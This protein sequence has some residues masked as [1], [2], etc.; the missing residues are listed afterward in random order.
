[1]LIALHL[2]SMFSGNCGSAFVEVLVRN[3]MWPQDK[4]FVTLLPSAVLMS[5]AECKNWIK[6]HTVRM[7]NNSM[8]CKGVTTPPCVILEAQ[9][10]F[11]R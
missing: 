11:P 7:F 2:H 10:G 6:T 9:E 3:S 1:M 8:Y 5:P 4:P